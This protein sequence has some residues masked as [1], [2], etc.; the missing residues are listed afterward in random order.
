MTSMRS[1]LLVVLSVLLLAGCGSSVVDKPGTARGAGAATMVPADATLYVGVVTDLD[2][3]GWKSVETLLARFPDGEQLLGTLAGAIGGEGTN[4]ERD[5]KPALGPV[6]AIVSLPGSGEPVALTKPSLRA[7]LDAL[8]GRADHSVATM[9]LDDGWVAVAEKQA[10]LDAYRSS[11]GGARL[12][13]DDDFSEAVGDL[14]EDALGTIFVRASGLNY[15]G[16]G[17]TQGIPPSALATGG[18]EW[19]GA[20]LTAKDDGLDLEGTVQTDTKVT[21]YEPTLLDRV[22]SGVVL[23]ASFHGSKDG[24]KAL[25]ESPALRSFVPMAEDALGVRLADVLQ[26]FEGQGVLYVRP[27]LPIPEVTLALDTDDAEG[28]VTTIDKIARR[29]GAQVETTTVDGVPAHRLRLDKVQATWAAFEGTLLVSTGP[30]ALADFRS[31]DAKLVDDASYTRATDRVELGD[32]TAGLVYV[33]VQ[34]MAELVDGLATAA[35]EDVPAELR[36][37]LA[38]IESFVGN[39]SADGSVVTL[40]GFLSVPAR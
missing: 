33:D 37:N 17:M 24:M 7:K 5:V 19:L 20:A 35:G 16:F 9:S 29:L 38:P 25:T 32:S 23:A 13:D 39:A 14:P 18:F 27:G 26:L 11:L 22:P 2:S 34:R 1:A 15:G 10:T 31:D 4:W 21:T 36:R 6:T 8:L 40:H 12:A 30:N 28:G 3:A